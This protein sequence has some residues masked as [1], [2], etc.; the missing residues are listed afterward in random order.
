MHSAQF[1]PAFYNSMGVILCHRQKLNSY[2]EGKG[3]IDSQKKTFLV[4]KWA[5]YPKG[6][7]FEKRYKQD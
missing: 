2:K 7:R 3:L 1:L 5:I 6:K 4:S